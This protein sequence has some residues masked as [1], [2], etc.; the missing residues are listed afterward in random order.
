MTTRLLSGTASSTN[1]KVK[2]STQSRPKTTGRK[3]RPVSKGRDRLGPCKNSVDEYSNPRHDM[4]SKREKAAKLKGGFCDFQTSENDRLF[5]STSSTMFFE[6]NNQDHS[7]KLVSIPISPMYGEVTPGPKWDTEFFGRGA[8][9]VP[10]SRAANTLPGLTEGRKRSEPKQIFNRSTNSQR[11]P[12]SARDSNYTR[13]I[14]PSPCSVANSIQSSDLENSPRSHHSGSSLS[15]G[16]TSG[17]SSG[18]ANTG[19]STA[20]SSEAEIEPWAYRIISKYQDSSYQR[21]MSRCTTRILQDSDNQ[22]EIVPPLLL[23]GM[24]KSMSCPTM[25]SPKLSA[26]Y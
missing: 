13:E 18:R 25:R 11:Q 21:P 6:N 3:S 9:S 19:R 5:I 8:T 16:A 17:M 23:N 10:S 15:R 24:T 20:V 7:E 26:L 12:N 1:K 2:E 4:K 22:A 14:S